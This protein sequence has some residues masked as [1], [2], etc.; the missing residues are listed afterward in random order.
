MK[1]GITGGSGFFGSLLIKELLSQGFNCLNID[2]VKSNLSHQNLKEIIVDVTSDEFFEFDLTGIELIFHNIAA[3][4]L[5][6]NKKLFKDTNVIGTKNVIESAIKY[7]VK[8]IINTSS[9]AIYGIPY[10]NPVNEDDVCVPIDPY[11]RA[12]LEAEKLFFKY[13]NDIEFLSIRPRTII[14]QERLG[15]FQI[16]Y[17]WII[18]N[19]NIP[20]LNG[21]NNIYQFLNVKDLIDFNIML[22]DKQLTN[23]VVNIG[24]REYKSL[25]HDL[26]DLISYTESK[27][28]IKSINKSFVKYSLLMTNF[29]NLTPLS[30]YHAMMYGESLY[31]DNLK[32]KN[33]FNFEPK[34]SNYET[35]V[36]G[37]NWYKFNREDILNK[38][39]QSSPHKQ[40]VKQR[41]LKFVPKLI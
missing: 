25:Y 29:F 5:L 26:S 35:L 21:G 3:V 11:G 41:F 32:L 1:I 6:N 13:E 8:K 10:L 9:S 14:G 23:S 31:F 20:V 2:I 38:S 28:Q 18:E 27:S 19:Q 24:C 37:F 7:K 30:T 39:I 17:E 33:E 16:L 15:I 4:P 34:Y 36:E 22:I 40:A 12:K